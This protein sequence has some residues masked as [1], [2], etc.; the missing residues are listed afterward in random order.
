[1]TITSLKTSS[2]FLKGKIFVV[3]EFIIPDRSL[4]KPEENIFFFLFYAIYGKKI[5]ERDEVNFM[6]KIIEKANSDDRFQR[7]LQ[8]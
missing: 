8:L 2:L 5:T 3:A 6:A 1:M 7:V 4:Y